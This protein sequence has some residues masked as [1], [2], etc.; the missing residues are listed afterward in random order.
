MI[1][2]LLKSLQIVIFFTFLIQENLRGIKIIKNPII[3]IFYFIT[4]VPKLF[5]DFILS[6]INKDYQ[7]VLGYHIH[8]RKK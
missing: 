7:L 2:K 8:A 6:K 1:L 5:L 3:K 4:L